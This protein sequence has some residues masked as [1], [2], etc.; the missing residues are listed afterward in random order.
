[1]MGRFFLVGK[2]VESGSHGIVVAV[3]FIVTVSLIF[4]QAMGRP[5]H[6]LDSD[7]GEEKWDGMPPFS[8]DK[9]NG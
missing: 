6:E 7:L 9:R 2:V 3:L 4:G 5:G 8:R 1:M